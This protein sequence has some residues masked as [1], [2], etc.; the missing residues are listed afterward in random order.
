MKKTETFMNTKAI[1]EKMEM[2]GER[3]LTI[4][5]EE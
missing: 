5:Q 1:F 2:E 4:N 3:V